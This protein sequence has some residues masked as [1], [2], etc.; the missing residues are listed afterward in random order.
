MEP[1]KDF[2]VYTAARFAV[3]AAT[4][5]VLWVVAGYF[6]ERTQ[7]LSIAVLFFALVISSII[8]IFTLAPLRDKLAFR[9]QNRAEQL[10]ERV[11]ESRRAE[12]VD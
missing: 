3:F 12:D 7:I 11:E 6:M 1:M 5:A 9:I 2:V 4:F 8:S 10:H